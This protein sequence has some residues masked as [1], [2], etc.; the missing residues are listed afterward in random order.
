MESTPSIATFSIARTATAMPD[1]LRF[2][3]WAEAG[4]LQSGSLG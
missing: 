1:G 2:L 3:P 4:G